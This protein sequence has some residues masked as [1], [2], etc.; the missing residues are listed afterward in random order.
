VT[1]YAVAGGDFYQPLEPTRAVEEHRLLWPAIVAWA[2]AGAV[3]WFYG[4]GLA[5]HAGLAAGLIAAVAVLWWAYGAGQSGLSAAVGSA[6]GV[7]AWLRCRQMANHPLSVE[8]GRRIDVVGRVEGS[9]RMLEHSMMLQLGI[10]GV[11]GTV[12]CFAPGLSLDEVHRGDFL[13]AAAVTQPSTRPGLVSVTC[14]LSEIQVVQASD[15]WAWIRGRLAQAAGR[16]L[17]SEHAGLFGGMAI[18]DTS[19][20]SAQQRQVFID[21]GLSHLS[22]VSGANVAIVLGTVVAL[23]GTQ[24]PKVRAVA[25]A[26]SLAVFIAV[27]GTEA[28]VIRAGIVG[29]VAVV[30]M[31][32]DRRTQPAHTL[33]LAVIAMVILDP[34]MALNYGFALSVVATGGIILLTPVLLR[35][36]FR[37]LPRIPMPWAQLLAV[38]LAAD[39]ST[40]PI[41]ALMAGR[42]SLVSLIANLLAGPAVPPVTILGLIATLTACVNTTA[43][44]LIIELTR[45]FLWWINTVADIVGKQPWATTHIP[46]QWLGLGLAWMLYALLWHDRSRERTS[47]SGRRTL[48][49]RTSTRRHHHPGQTTTTPRHRPAHHPA[50]RRRS[51][52]ERNV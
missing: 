39:L 12:P 21:T 40:M 26:I 4:G 1:R 44:S 13:A 25:A 35:S 6:A 15:P 31:V 27:V 50:A 23:L 10:D 37:I 20:Q 52:V 46:T 29:S 33:F 28:S 34:G 19:G 2:S 49:G 41:I 45:P 5:V 43:A 48:P 7:V 47:D 3:I 38:T 32:S 51:N 42:T 9:P 8:L 30:T 11:P 22:A 16:V 36:I 14:R 17:S 18:G 24:A